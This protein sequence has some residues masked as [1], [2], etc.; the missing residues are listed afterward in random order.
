[1]RSIS[2][3]ANNVDA[4][5]ELGTSAASLRETPSAMSRATDWA[6]RREFTMSEICGD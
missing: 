1:M 6:K 4:G 2:V 5:P 3:A